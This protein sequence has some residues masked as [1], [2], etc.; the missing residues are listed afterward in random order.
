M[1]RGRKAHHLGER[2]LLWNIGQWNGRAFCQRN[3]GEG[4][5]GEG[6]VAAAKDLGKTKSDGAII[7]FTIF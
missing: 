7:W 1:G 2:I 4:V 5:C 6:L 3:V